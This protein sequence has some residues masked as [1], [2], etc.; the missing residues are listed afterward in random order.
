MSA[1]GSY[2][3][4]QTVSHSRPVRPIA[5]PCGALHQEGCPYSPPLWSRVPRDFSTRLPGDCSL[6]HQLLLPGR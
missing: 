6:I 5:R 1:L 2:S 4:R 3:Y